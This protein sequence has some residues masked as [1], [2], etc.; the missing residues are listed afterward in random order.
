MYTLPFAENQKV[1]ELGGG[2]NPQFH[3][4]LDVRGEPG[5]DQ[6]VDLNE[7]LPLDSREWDGVFCRYA[8]EHLSWRKIRG[9]VQE[10]YRVLNYGG[11]AV[12]I[13]ANLLEQ[14]RIITENPR[15]DD[16]S[17]G[18]VFG[19]ND[20]PENTHRA[21]FSPE[22]A[23]RIFKEAGFDRVT[24]IRHPNWRGDMII[25][26]SKALLSREE[27]FDKDYFHGGTKVGGY[28]HEGYRDFYQHWFTFHKIMKLKPESVLELGCARGYTLKK[29]ED[30]GVRIGGLEIS[31]HCRLTRVVDNITTWDMCDLPWPFAD[32]QF[33][34]CFSV[35]VLEHIPEEFIPAI[36]EEIDR[37]SKR[38]IHGV[39]FGHQDDGFDKTHVT[40]KPIEWWKEHFPKRQKIV[41]KESF[42]KPP[43]GVLS[44]DLVP[45]G[46]GKLKVNVGCYTHMFHD[47]WCNIDIV[48]LHDFAK[49]NAYKFYH[50]DVREGLPFA[51]E[52]VDL[53]YTSHFFEHLNF[54]EGRKFLK[55]CHRVLKKDGVMRFIIPDAELLIEKYRNK[56]LSELDELSPYQPSRS[57]SQKLWAFLCGGH[58]AMYDFAA[59]QQL[60]RE[61]GFRVERKGFRE[62]HEQL[63]KETLDT[64]PDLSLFIQMRRS[65]GQTIA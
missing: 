64:L 14:A 20:Y 7:K 26:A 18:M 50:K 6:V 4:N 1:V 19:D 11:T 41:D 33:D 42:E 46:D 60:G 12:F 31:K 25:E 43:E 23:S 30:A 59:M 37:V 28:A 22:S 48:P 24:I 55:E 53:L 32:K 56:E 65:D 9:F 57:D 40:L 2:G 54:E 49:D 16:N 10:V 39:D 8:I 15:L 47:G 52:T 35:A 27:K 5:V 51:D 44:F 21:G 17:V 61:L 34:L 36:V 62:G 29:L 45:V 58:Q 38:G 13:T 63:I 3:P